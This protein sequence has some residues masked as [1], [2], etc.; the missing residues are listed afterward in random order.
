MSRNVV[1]PRLNLLRPAQVEQVHQ[2]SLRILAD[3]GLRVD[4]PR[5]RQALARVARVEGERVRIPPETVEWALRAAPSAIDV[6]NRRGERV[7]R[8]GDDRTRFGVGVTVLNYQH[9]LT[10]E[11]EPFARPHMAALT[12]LANGLPLFDVVS[13]VGILHD[14]PPSV[15]DLYATLE[16]VANT[17]KPLVILV[18]EEPAFPAVLDLLEHLHGDLAAQPFV[19]PYVNPVTPLVLNTGTSDKMFVAIERGLPLIFSNYGMAGMSTPLTPAGTLALMNAEL[20]AGLVLSQCIREGASVILGCLPA[21]FDMKTMV[22]FYDPQSMLVSLA[23]AEMMSH[24]HL[25]HC[26]TSGSGN[27]WGPDLPAAEMQW[28]NHLLA[29]IGKVGLAPFVGDTLNSKAISPVGVVYGHEII[30]QA[31]RFAGGFGLEERDWALDEVAQVGPGGNFLMSEHTLKGY[32]DG[33]YTSPFFPR[34]SMERWQEGGRPRAE[35]L[36]RRYTADLLARLPMP[37]DH[38]D[39]LSRGEAFIESARST[40]R[41]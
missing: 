31:L 3:V 15:A 9:P 13:T 34:W 11:L 18:S 16:M 6:Y 39:L 41:S 27:G 37:D 7:F 35:D 20:L 28:M 23:C 36:L 8:L 2:A 40:N 5:A 22:S 17:V 19:I 4:S 29:V 10:D 32:R 33:Y 26:G 38:D 12:R 24:Y 25:P 30:A 21:Y 1:H 14:V